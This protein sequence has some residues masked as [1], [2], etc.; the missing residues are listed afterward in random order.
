MYSPKL[1]NYHLFLIKS[2]TIFSHIFSTI[3]FNLSNTVLSQGKYNH[4]RRQLFSLV[5][6]PIFNIFQ[7]PEYLVRHIIQYSRLIIKHTPDEPKAYHSNHVPVSIT[8][9]N[10]ESYK[11]K[12]T[13]I[14]H[15][16]FLCQPLV[17]LFLNFYANDLLFKQ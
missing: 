5:Y 10:T 12:K 3:E 4:T 6:I 1:F 17:D 8:N 2:F 11:N 14:L 16:C 7:L 15:V 9:I 13:K